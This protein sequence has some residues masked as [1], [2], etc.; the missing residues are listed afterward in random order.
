MN[1]AVNPITATI[2]IANDQTVER[3]VRSS[4]HSAAS[5]LPKF[6]CPPSAVEAGAIASLIDHAPPPCVA[7]ALAGAA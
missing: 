5:S 6:A 1:S 2:R 3:T 4:V 7:L